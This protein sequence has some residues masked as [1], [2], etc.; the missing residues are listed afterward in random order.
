MVGKDEGND[1]SNRG[2]KK[3]RIMLETIHYI[4]E[5][6]KLKLGIYKEKGALYG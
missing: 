3:K 6:L 2:K 4:I 5:E 1:M